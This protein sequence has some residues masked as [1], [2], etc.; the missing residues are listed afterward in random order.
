M[1][2][3]T[4]V[5]VL[6]FTNT[7]M[8]FARD[9]YADRYDVHIEILEKNIIEVTEQVDFVFQRGMFTHVF[10]EFPLMHKDSI[11]IQQILMDGVPIDRGKRA[12]QA[13]IRDAIPLR[14]LWHFKPMQNSV[15]SFSITYRVTGVIQKGEQS[16]IFNWNTIPDDHEY[17]I[18]RAS[19]AITYPKRAK[20]LALS[21][22]PQEGADIEYADTEIRIRMENLRKYHAYKVHMEF[23]PGSL[24]EEAPLWQARMEF[25]RMKIPLYLSIGAIIAIVGVLLI[26]T[27]IKSLKNS[28]VE[29]RIDSPVTVPPDDMSPALV[30]MILHPGIQPNFNSAIGTLFDFARR[31]IVEFQQIKQTMKWFSRSK[32]IVVLKQEPESLTASER[33]FLHL[34]FKNRKG[35]AAS[36]D[37]SELSSRYYRGSK[38]FFKP[39]KEHL[40]QSGYIDSDKARARI[41]LML[42]YGILSFIFLISFIPCLVFG[43]PTGYWPVIFVPA[44]LLYASLYGLITAGLYSPFSEKG[45]NRYYAWKNFAQYLRHII[46]GKEPLPPTIRFDSYIQYAACFGM[47]HTW[48]EFFRKKGTFDPPEWLKGFSLHPDDWKSFYTMMNALSSSGASSGGGGGSSGTG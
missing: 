21:T 19:I 40:K 15:H 25:A 41:Q 11:S 12:G 20:L 28:S 39:L 31:G 27:V 45:L 38:Y 24:I 48:M 36:F 2:R 10:K 13:E 46:K 4:A 8:L 34:L 29:V 18:R 42:A 22:K 17:H 32:Y 37:I 7:L 1:K 6:I 14:V 30:S 44:G 47:L 26:G 9:Y 3:N 43:I 23:Q 5:V 33:G 16:D 35:E